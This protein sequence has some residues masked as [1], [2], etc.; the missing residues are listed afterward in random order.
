MNIRERER[1]RANE[2]AKE[3][4]KNRDKEV[5]MFSVHSK[6]T[7]SPLFFATKRQKI[8][9]SVISNNKKMRI[10]I[11]LFASKHFIILIRLFYGVPNVTPF[12]ERLYQQGW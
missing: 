10:I 6:I 5:G 2:R 8:S 4:E 3:R 12:G 11:M 1:E 7:S 9:V